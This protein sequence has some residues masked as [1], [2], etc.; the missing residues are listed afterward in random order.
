MEGNSAEGAGVEHT[1]AENS[2]KFLFLKGMVSV[3]RLD[4][5]SPPCK[6]FSMSGR[7]N[8]LALSLSLKKMVIEISF[9]ARSEILQ[10]TENFVILQRKDILHENL[11]FFDTF[12]QN[13]FWKIVQE[14]TA[15]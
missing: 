2:E 8:S 10:I 6:T 11:W 7:W 4:I 12:I 9:L 14:F 1:I 3:G 15:Q 13:E 5:I